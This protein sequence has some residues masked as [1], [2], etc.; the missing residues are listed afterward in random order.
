MGRTSPEPDPMRRFV[1]LEELPGAFFGFTPQERARRLRLYLVQRSMGMPPELA[2][3]FVLDMSPSGYAFAKEIVDGC[4][5]D[6]R[7]EQALAPNVDHRS[8]MSRG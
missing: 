2:T 4:R 6:G 5:P 8:T 1:D 3:L 7:L